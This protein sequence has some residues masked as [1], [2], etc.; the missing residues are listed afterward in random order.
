[1]VKIGEIEVEKLLQLYGSEY[2][3]DR[4]KMEQGL[5]AFKK[6]YKDSEKERK[7]NYEN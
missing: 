2:E 3:M 4:M 7:Q 1:M 5:R 6:M